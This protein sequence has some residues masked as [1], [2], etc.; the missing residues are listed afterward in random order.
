MP[1]VCWPPLGAFINHP[2]CGW[3]MI[4]L[5]VLQLALTSYNI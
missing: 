1:W 2:L 4:W 3:Y 5:R